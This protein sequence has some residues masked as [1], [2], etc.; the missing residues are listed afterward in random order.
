MSTSCVLFWAKSLCL[1]LL[2]RSERFYLAIS[3]GF[4]THVCTDLCKSHLQVWSSSSWI[5][6][7]LYIVPWDKNGTLTKVFQ[8]RKANISV[9]TVP[10]QHVTHLELFTVQNVNANRARGEFQES[11]SWTRMPLCCYVLNGSVTGP[12]APLAVCLPD[13]VGQHTGRWLSLL[14]NCLHARQ[15]QSSGCVDCC[16]S[17]QHTDMLQGRACARDY[18]QQAI[19]T[20]IPSFWGGGEGKEETMIC[21]AEPCCA[22]WPQGQGMGPGYFTC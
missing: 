16:S 11:N 6:S 19:S 15:H 13:G 21:K 17:R 14:S 18:S 10:V 22:A 12:T 9:T 7:L 3:L 4:C 2:D 5:Q 1:C 8:S 20:Q